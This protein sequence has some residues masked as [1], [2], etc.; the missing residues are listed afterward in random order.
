MGD[1]LAAGGMPHGGGDAHLDAEL[2]GPVCLA[3]AD[4]LDLWRVQGIDLATALAALLFKHA[5]GEIQ[6]PHERFPQ[7]LI[8]GNVPLDVANDPAEI[9]LELAQAP[10]GAF[11]LMGMGVTLVRDDLVKPGAEQILLAALPPLAWPHRKSPAPSARARR[12]TA[13][14]SRESSKS[15]LQGSRPPKAKNRQIR[16]LERAQSSSPFNGF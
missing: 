3:L 2:V 15:N 16:L 13:F 11:E 1:E 4:A 5:P 7:N 14:D 10:V 6:R 9:G 12:I 8:P